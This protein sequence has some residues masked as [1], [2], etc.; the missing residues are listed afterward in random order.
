MIPNNGGGAIFSFLGQRDLPEFEPLF[1][2]PHG[3]DLRAISE[4]SGAG[5]ERVERMSEFVRAIE[6]AGEARGIRVVEVAV[7]PE[8]NRERHAEVQVA[9]DAA[10][11]R[12]GRA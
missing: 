2:T 9:V 4:A 8:R 11:G 12:T 6:R 10:I 3:L 1:A 5:H 7:D